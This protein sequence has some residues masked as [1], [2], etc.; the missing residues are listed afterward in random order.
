M[1][2]DDVHYLSGSVHM[3]ACAKKVDYLQL[4]RVFEG[5]FYAWPNRLRRNAT[6]NVLDVSLGKSITICCQEKKSG[7]KILIFHGE[8]RFWKFRLTEFSDFLVET[9][10]I[11][12]ISDVS[13]EFFIGKSWKCA[14][15]WHFRGK[16]SIEIF[17]IKFLHEK[18]I[19][20]VQIFFPD[21]IWLYTSPKLH[22]ER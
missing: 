8:I 3:K 6:P 15:I 18:L 16:I 5:V 1:D 2:L 21:N 14:K 9:T 11:F 20:F 10:N 13:I 17:K 12:E 4:E 22:P 7:P 19:F